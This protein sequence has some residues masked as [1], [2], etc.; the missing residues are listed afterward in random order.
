MRVW[1]SSFNLE[2]FFAFR[3]YIKAALLPMQPPVNHVCCTKPVMDL[4]KPTFGE[5]FPISVP[6]NKLYTKT[7]QVNV[8]CTSGESEECLVRTTSFFLKQCL[9]RELFFNSLLCLPTGFSPSLTGRLQSRKPERKVVQHPVVPLH[10]ALQ[11][12]LLRGRFAISFVV[13]AATGHQARQARV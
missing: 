12:I 10:A 9:G 3:R 13:A 8:L 1:S 4:R 2:V 11:L 7:L 6:L 5:T